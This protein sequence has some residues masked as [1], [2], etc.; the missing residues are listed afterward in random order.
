MAIG[1]LIIIT[2]M[3]AGHYRLY[4]HAV[5]CFGVVFSYRSKVGP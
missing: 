2:H 1:P 5:S 3:W 4:V